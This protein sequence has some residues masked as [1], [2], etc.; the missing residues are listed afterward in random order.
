METIAFALLLVLVMVM[1]TNFR[2]G[3]LG[4]WFRAK[5]LGQGA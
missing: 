5:F 2:N 4:Q 1:F 3:T